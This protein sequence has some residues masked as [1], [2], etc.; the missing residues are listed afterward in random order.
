MAEDRNSFLTT[1][2]MPAASS[3]FFL[4]CTTCRLYELKTRFTYR[5]K[6]A[7][8]LAAQMKSFSDSPPTAWVEYSTRHL[9]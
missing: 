3:R 6:S 2:R 7:S 8:A 4:W 1:A 5:L 9:L